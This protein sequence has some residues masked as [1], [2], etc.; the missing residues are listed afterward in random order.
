MRAFTRFTVEDTALAWLEATGWQVERSPDIAPDMR[1]AERCD[2]GEVEL[3]QR[4]CDA[5]QQKL[6]SAEVRVKNGEQFINRSTT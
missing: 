3:T 4:L 1:A 2:Y 5:L 6:I